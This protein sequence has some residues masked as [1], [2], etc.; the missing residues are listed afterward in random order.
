MRIHLIHFHIRNLDYAN[1]KNC[2]ISRIFLLEPW[3]SWD[4]D[5]PSVLLRYNKST[6]YLLL[7]FCHRHTLTLYKR[8]GL[9]FLMK[10]QVFLLDMLYSCQNYLDSCNKGCTCYSASHCPSASILPYSLLAV[11]LSR[12]LYYQ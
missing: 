2:L 7:L 1:Y 12:R 6:C 8:D 10:L 11:V 5:M 4:T 3:I 9:C